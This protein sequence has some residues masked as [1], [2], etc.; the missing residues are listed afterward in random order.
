M[1]ATRRVSIAPARHTD[2]YGMQV[3]IGECSTAG[4][5][6][7]QPYEETPPPLSP[8]SLHFEVLNST[9]M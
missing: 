1:D 8:E 7:R 2:A 4:S 6:A 9:C 5:Q 3:A